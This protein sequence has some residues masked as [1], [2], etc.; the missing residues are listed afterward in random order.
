MAGSCYSTALLAASLLFL[1][2]HFRLSTED[3]MN[4]LGENQELFLCSG[5]I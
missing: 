5:L 2:F 3:V 4:L 1:P